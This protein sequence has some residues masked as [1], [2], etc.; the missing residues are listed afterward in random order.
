MSD[1]QKTGLIAFI[2]LIGILVFCFVYASIKT[3]R[4]VIDTLIDFLGQLPMLILYAAVPCAPALIL[5]AKFGT[6]SL[7]WIAI[8]ATV[9]AAILCLL[10]IGLPGELLE[11]DPVI[12]YESAGEVVYDNVNEWIFLF[13]MF[14]MNSS[15][16]VLYCVAFAGGLYRFPFIKNPV[17]IVLAPSFL[18]VLIILFRRI[19]FSGLMEVFEFFVEFAT[20]NM[21]MTS[22][23][24]AV[25]ALT[26]LLAAHLICRGIKKHERLKKAL[27]KYAPATLAV[28]AV[29]AA[30]F[31]ALP[32]LRPE[33]I[34]FV[35]TYNENAGIYEFAYAGS[36]L[37]ISKEIFDEYGLTDE[38]VRKFFEGAEIVYKKLTDFFPKYG[39]P[40]TVF[41]RAVPEQW[42]PE[43]A[44]LG[45][46]YYEDKSHL[47]SWHDL[48]TNEIFC[49]EN[50]FAQRL[51]TIDAGFPAVVCRELS[52]FYTM[53]AERRYMEHYIRPYVW[54]PEFFAVLAEYYIA[55]FIPVVNAGGEIV[56]ADNRDW[57]DSNYGQF[58]GLA[59]KYGYKIIS[60]T[61]KKVNNSSPD[62]NSSQYH[63]LTLFVKFLSQ[64]T[65]DDIEL[66]EVY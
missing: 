41:Y 38:H 49:E 55:S 10:Y 2:V 63:P 61:L 20:M 46:E 15:I 1:K 29:S 36:E 40:K 13:I 25:W 42:R 45:Y 26:L 27:T 39:F 58:F 56:T 7:G 62:F 24:Y 23:L 5:R 21:L 57:E 50:L 37:H 16:P 66:R 11:A 59:D 28:A 9:L 64:K 12:V 8:A 53:Y 34:V 60:D 19:I 54:D 17:L 52:Y 32:M 43:L 51:C 65:K 3:D 35:K 48:W 30:A 18:F 47:G 6:R 44:E 31:T 33:E 4:S 22:I 14:A